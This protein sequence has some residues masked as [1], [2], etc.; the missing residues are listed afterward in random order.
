MIVV[1]FVANFYQGT[2]EP[3]V[4]RDASLNAVQQDSDEAFIEQQMLNTVSS[5]VT[6]YIVIVSG[7]VLY[8]VIVSGSVVRL[9]KEASTEP[10]EKET[11]KKEKEKE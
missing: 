10:E 11:P 8:F 7:I 1:A 2:V 4:K 9:L 5:N 6:P 3:I